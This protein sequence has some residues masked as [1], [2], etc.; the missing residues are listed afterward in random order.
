[1]TQKE[2]PQNFSIHTSLKVG[3]EHKTSFWEGN[4]LGPGPLRLLFPDAFILNQQQRANISEVW[5]NQGWDLSFRRLPNDW[6]TEIFKEFL[7]ILD[8][9][10]RVSL[11]QDR[12]R[13]LRDSSRI[14]SVKTAY[15]MRKNNNLNV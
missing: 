12:L 11:E 4:W 10:K 9:F 1:M 6:E 15:H 7:N 14:F 3:N 2:W 5:S 13:W 8:L